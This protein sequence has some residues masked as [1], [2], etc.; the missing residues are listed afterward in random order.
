MSA[1]K[2]LI[3]KFLPVLI[4]CGI[5]AACELYGEVGGDDT[6]I[7]GS[8]PYLLQGQWAYGSSEK[9]TITATTIEYTYEGGPPDYNYKGD[10]KFVSNYSADSG[11][12]IIEYIIKPGYLAY[13]DKDF[14]AIYYRNLNANWVKLAN[15]INLSDFTAPDTETLN[16][17][18]QKFTRTQ[19]GNYVNWNFQPQTRIGE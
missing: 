4:L 14:F 17:A 12:I 6:N 5:L 1:K 18:I 7:P 3:Y 11:V 8:L 15:A 16:E 9:Y 2:F 13:N 19:M 10:I